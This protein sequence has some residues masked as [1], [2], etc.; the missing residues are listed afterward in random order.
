MDKRHDDPSDFQIPERRHSR[1]INTD[2]GSWWFLAREGM[3]GP[4]ETV[5]Q[6]MYSLE[7]FLEVAKCESGQII[8][9][10]AIA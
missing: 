4:F 8:N 3:M 2:D 5:D 7:S 6:A 10:G 9:E 1:I